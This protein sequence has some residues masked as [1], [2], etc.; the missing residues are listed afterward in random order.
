MKKGKEA[1]HGW[2]VLAR[3]LAG[4]PVAQPPSQPHLV[5]GLLEALSRLTAIL[6]AL[7]LV[8]GKGP[9]AGRARRH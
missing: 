7:P 1:S 6:D 8:F 3:G 9:A 2:S 5:A 4:S